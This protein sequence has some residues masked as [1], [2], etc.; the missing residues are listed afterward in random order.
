ML[1]R[2]P[3]TGFA[4]TRHRSSRG[5]SKL[6]DRT[7]LSPLN[8]EMGRG[9]EAL[10]RPPIPRFP[11]HPSGTGGEGSDGSE[12]GAR[13][14]RTIP[15]RLGMRRK[16]GPTL[17]SAV[18]KHLG[19]GSAPVLPCKK[20]PAGHPRSPPGSAVQVKRKISVW[21]RRATTISS[22]CLCPVIPGASGTARFGFRYTGIKVR[23]VLTN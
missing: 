13:G 14:C 5:V 22:V 1:Q 17:P 21:Q 20:S 6:Q 10:C 2:S 8:L 11:A 16:S 4:L 18:G 23:A 7:L 3:R 19:T 9:R 12:R 15:A